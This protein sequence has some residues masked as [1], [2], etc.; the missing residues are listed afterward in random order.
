MPLGAGSVSD[1]HGTFADASG[2]DGALARHGAGL[3]PHQLRFWELIWNLPRRHLNT[4]LAAPGR[5]VW[6][7]RH[8]P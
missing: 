7:R 3:S 5:A 1:G 8:H 4:W 2:S 6:D